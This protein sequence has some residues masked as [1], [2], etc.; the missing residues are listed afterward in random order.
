MSE[1]LN[2]ESEEKES[3]RGRS[4]AKKKKQKQPKSF[5]GKAF[6]QTKKPH[7]VVFIFELILCFI[8]DILRLLKNLILGIIIIGIVCAVIAGCVV[9]AKVKPIYND[10]KEVADNFVN[11]STEDTFRISESSYIYDKDGNVIAKLKADMDSSYL[12]FEDIP[13]EVIDAFVAVEDR[14]FWDNPGIDVKGLVRVGV[15][16]I[17]SKG[18]ELHGASTITQQL[19]RNIFLTHEVSIERK[20]KEMLISLA[21]TQKYSKRDIMEFYVN[22]ICFANAYYGIEAASIGYFNKR[23]SELNLSEIAYLAAIP[24]SPSYYD[25]YKHPER[26]IPRRNKILG[27]MLEM[28]YISQKEHDEAVAYE[29]VITR[30]EIEFNNFETTYAIDCAVKYI[31][32]LNNFEFKYEFEKMSDYKNY[33]KD[34]NDAYSVAK[35]Q[36]YCGGYQVYTTIDSTKQA[37]LQKILNKELSFNKDKNEE[38]GLYELQGAITAIDNATGKVVAIIGGRY[39]DG[40]TD[41]Y[42]L[43]R[44]FQSPRQ[45]GSSIKP[46]IVYAPAMENGFRPS[47]VVQNISV[48]AAKDKDVDI[49]T[50]TGESMTIRKALELSKNGVAWKL[51]TDITPKLGL[52]YI[53]NMEFESIVPDDYYA[54]ASLGGLTYG[55]TTTEMAGAYAALANHGQFRNVTCIDKMIDK[56]GK[57]IYRESSEKQVYKKRSADET[58]D[59]MKGVLISGTASRL[60][61]SKATDVEA[62]AKT[63][64]TNSNKDGWLC[65]TTPYYTVAVWVGYDTPKAMTSLQGSTYPGQIWKGSMLAL[66]GDIEV[67]KFIEAE[68]TEEDKLEMPASYYEYL[69][70]RDDSEMLS[71]G[72][73][74]ADY[75]NDRVIGED[76]DRVINEILSLNRADA[77]FI[78]LL[79]IKKAEA[80]SIIDSIY[81]QKY[82]AEKQGQLDT[83][84]NQIM[85]EIN[86]A[87]APENPQ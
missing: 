51:F 76:V 75:R 11:S 54:A 66:L 45:P 61:W 32:K 68:Y 23:V 18:E 72:Y 17:K 33:L 73:S 62:A 9:L 64:T 27:D 78:T 2:K 31:M 57:D 44:A 56:Y 1:I 43:N 24:N 74:V 25:P 37:E 20:A 83:L 30:P 13:V 86:G 59:M 84:Y 52:S 60:G 7:I 77:N 42:S 70:G 48:E 47:T 67:G 36:L 22:D 19:S 85:S 39:E 3:S 58:I 41:S 14:T 29:I 12:E 16:A 28:N 65:G 80:Q 63:G 46:L 6:K 71:S 69:P 82:T 21:L 55:V 10:Y 50:L 81:S 38:T 40:D 4:R 34:Y 15:D 8:L 87:V 35:N 79:E 49:N 5:M 53:T 26:A